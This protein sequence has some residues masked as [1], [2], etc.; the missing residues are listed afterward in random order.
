MGQKRRKI[1]THIDWSK[2]PASHIATPET[3]IEG[4][5]NLYL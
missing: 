4:K 5:N 1:E 3:M 2:P